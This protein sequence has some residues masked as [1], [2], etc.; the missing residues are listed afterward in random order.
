MVPF[1]T[2]QSSSEK[3]YVF[4]LFHCKLLNTIGKYTRYGFFCQARSHGVPLLK[5]F[6][7]CRSVRV[8]H[9]I[10]HV[11][12]FR[13]F[14]GL[15]SH[16]EAEFCLADIMNALQMCL[17]HIQR[18]FGRL[19][20]ALSTVNRQIR[21]ACDFQPLLKVFLQMGQVIRMPSWSR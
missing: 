15:L 13:F 20:L 16:H 18:A 2:L 3:I 4:I 6:P 10:M 19:N 9:M 11:K 8:F 1:V 14:F 7:W 21:Y 5:E 17:S 12:L